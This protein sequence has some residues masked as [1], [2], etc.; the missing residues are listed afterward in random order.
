MHPLLDVLGTGE[1]IG[2]VGPS[3]AT[4]DEDHAGRRDPGHEEAVVVGAADHVLGAEAEMLGCRSDRGLDL[5][6]AGGW[7]VL[8]NHRDLMSHLRVKC[9]ED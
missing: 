9:H 4:R 6:A 5:I 1:L 3:V 2:P 7:G 8:I